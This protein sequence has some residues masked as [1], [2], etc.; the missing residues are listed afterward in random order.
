MATDIAK[1]GS[2]LAVA[3][4][5]PALIF[6][7]GVIWSKIAGGWTNSTLRKGWMSSCLLLP[8]VIL[9]MIVRFGFAS[10]RAVWLESPFLSSVIFTFVG[11]VVPGFLIAAVVRVWCPRGVETGRPPAD[12]RS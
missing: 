8:I 7:A 12:L 3:C 9:G 6:V 1:I 5:M 11:I 2:A 4:I 10:L